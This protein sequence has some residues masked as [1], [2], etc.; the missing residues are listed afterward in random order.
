MAI[1]KVTPADGQESVW[2]YPRPPKCERTASRVQVLADGLT[3]ADSTACF[4]VL[5]TSHPPVYYIP[6]DDVDQKLITAGQGSSYCEWK[7]AARYVDLV[8]PDRR[9]PQVAWYYANPT[10]TFMEIRNFLAFYPGRVSE[11][12]V[13]GE[14][15]Q[16]QAGGFYGG[17][18]TSRVVGPFKGEPGT[19]GW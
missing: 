11:C 9:V 7:G 6:P 15:V 18:I 8:L 12:L 16:P 1:R 17:W 3:V 2:D 13:D 14:R 19:M 10:A 4:R 5:E